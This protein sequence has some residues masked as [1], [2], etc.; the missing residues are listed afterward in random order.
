MTGRGFAALNHQVE[1]GVVARVAM[2]DLA[3]IAR[4]DRDAHGFLER[5]VNH[6]RDVPGAACTARFV[7]TARGA[8]LGGDSNLFS[9]FILLAGS[10]SGSPRW[11]G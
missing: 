4:I 3:D 1:D 11:G 8:H 7:L 6:R 2:G 9:H 5:S 10:K